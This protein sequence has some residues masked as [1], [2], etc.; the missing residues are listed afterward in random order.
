MNLCWAPVFF[1][2]KGLRAALALNVL[3]LTSL[4]PI[5]LKFHAVDP[6][7]AYLVV[8]YTLWIS[9]ATALNFAICK[10]NPD[11]AAK[12]VRKASPKA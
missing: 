7:A 2:M 3:L 4:F 8:P 11:F 12:M 9:F 10:L 6:V 5:L 1:G